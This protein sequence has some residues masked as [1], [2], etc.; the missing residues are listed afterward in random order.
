[1]GE[2]LN[3]KRN[4]VRKYACLI[5]FSSIGYNLYVLKS[6]RL[7]PKLGRNLSKKIVRRRITE[8]DDQE[9]KN[10]AKRFI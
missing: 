5:F 9:G 7:I 6:V 1:M 10:N 3:R 8:N 2:M 4:Q